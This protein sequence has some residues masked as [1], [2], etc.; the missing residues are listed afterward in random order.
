MKSAA[1]IY[2]VAEVNIWYNRTELCPVNL[3]FEFDGST[4]DV[5]VSMN[6]AD[7]RSLHMKMGELLSALETVDKFTTPR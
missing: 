4:E 3:H 6:E 1:G 5:T 2:A 7:A